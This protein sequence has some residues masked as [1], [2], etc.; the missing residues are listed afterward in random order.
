MKKLSYFVG[1]YASSPN[2]VDW[3]ADLET[4]Y[5]QQLKLL[6]N[7]RGLEHPF[8]GKLHPHDDAWFLENISTEWD[9]LFTCIPGIMTNLARNPDFGLASENE[10]ARLEALEFMQQ[11][12]QAIIT[13]NTHVGRQA[14]SAI[15]IQTAPSTM[16][17]NSSAMA[18]QKSLETMLAWDWQGA[19]LVI[20]HCDQWVAGQSVAK[21]FL[22]LHDE[23]QVLNNIKQKHP[24]SS[25]GMI[26][27][28]GRSVLEA[29]NVKGAVNHILA[30]KEAGLLS[31]VMFSGVSDQES[32]YGCWQDTHMPP[33]PSKTNNYGEKTSL[34]NEIEIQNCLQAAGGQQDSLDLLGI[35][36]GIRPHDASIEERLAYNKAA[37]SMLDEFYT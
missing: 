10:S 21:G 31:G 11:A 30:V 13:L 7:I 8:L 22:S 4:Q 34:L 26:I 27:N 36:L 33:Q 16:Q 12:R 20:E 25:L 24:E 19:Q 35:K 37:L 28:W 1:A 32:E 2:V 17:A 3:D 14:V 18:L 6:P 15:E 9:F 23:I 29:R 5:Y